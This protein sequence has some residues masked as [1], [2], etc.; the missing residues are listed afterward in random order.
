MKI[1]DGWV[2][3]A[4]EI[5]YIHKS[6]DRLGHKITHIVLHGTAGGSSAENIANYFATSIVESSAHII[7]GQDGHIVQGISMNDAAWANGAL[8]AGHAA[9]LPEFVNPNLYTISIEHTKSSTD[10]S[11]SLTAAQ[12]AASFRLIACICDTYHIPKRAGDAGGGII[13]HADIDPINRARCPGPY[14][15]TDLWAF[16]KPV[17]PYTQK[18]AL[19]TWNSTAHLFGGKPL[20]DST[21]IAKAWRKHYESG[22]PLPPPMT[23]EFASVDLNGKPVVVQIFSTIRCEWDG[24]AR[25]YMADGGIQ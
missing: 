24:T 22:K 5:D 6:M 21:G 18:A 25:W 10:N 2:D 15:W 19:D 13:S 4:I 3:E 14:P 8:T 16:L 1:V 7:I 17:N 9:Y 20:N 12:Q 11:N 23:P